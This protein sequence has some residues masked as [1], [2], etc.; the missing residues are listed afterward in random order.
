MADDQMI[1]DPDEGESSRT[2]LELKNERPSAK[3]DPPVSTA[4]ATAV[5]T[6]VSSVESE[7][8][9]SHGQDSK[10]ALLSSLPAQLTVT[11]VTEDSSPADAAAAAAAAQALPLPPASSLA[12]PRAFTA[13]YSVADYNAAS[14]SRFG[15]YADYY[16]RVEPARGAAQYPTGPQQPLRPTAV[17][18]CVPFTLYV[19]TCLSSGGSSR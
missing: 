3:T 10:S 6:A 8:T 13:G 5:S 9:T 4:A 17:A 2:I 11:M 16:K 14:Q 15:Y 18:R 19:C 7:P 12:E 1:L